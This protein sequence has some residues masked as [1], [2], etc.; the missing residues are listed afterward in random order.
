M[1]SSNR[2]RR[3]HGLDD[4]DLALWRAV[5]ADVMPLVP[6]TESAPLPVPPAAAQPPA[7]PDMPAPKSRDRMLRR[8]ERASR[9][10]PPPPEKGRLTG[11]DGRNAQRLRRGKA[12]IEARIDLHGMTQARAH[13]ALRSFLEHQQAAGARVV[14]VITGKG[15]RAAPGADA[16]RGILHSVVPHWLGQ[17]PF[18]S[19]VVGFVH[20]QPQHGGE[21]ALY[22]R[23]RRAGRGRG[24]RERRERPS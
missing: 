9:Q 21:G 13:S 20:A 1:P 22:V 18:S 24:R 16:G 10:S 23:L 7:E 19:L 3:T 4:A 17:A 8:H 5:T 14:L 6:E 15:G 12:E 2:R 11:L